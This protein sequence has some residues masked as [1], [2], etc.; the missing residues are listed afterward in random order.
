MSNYIDAI[1]QAVA[2][3]VSA[4]YGEPLSKEAQSSLPANMQEAILTKLEN[5]LVGLAE[6]LTQT[7]IKA[8]RDAETA[9]TAKPNG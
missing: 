7:F 8:I 2:T 9:E 5:R 4:C 1:P 3:I 6:R